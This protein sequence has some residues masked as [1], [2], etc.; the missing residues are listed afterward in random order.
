MHRMVYYHPAWLQVHVLQPQKIP[1]KHKWSLYYKEK[2]DPQK[3]ST[4][5]KKGGLSKDV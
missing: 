2:N 3:L 5:Y 4:F 1:I